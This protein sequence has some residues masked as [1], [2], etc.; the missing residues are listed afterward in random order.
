MFI[1]DTMTWQSLGPDQ[2]QG[3][4]VSQGDQ[5][6]APPSSGGP[7]ARAGRCAASIGSRLYIWSGRDGYRK[8]W[9]YQV[10]CQDLWYLETGEE[11]DKD[12]INI[13]TCLIPVAQYVLQSHTIFKAY[14]YILI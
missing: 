8:S 7:R 11:R 2:Q 5:E 4:T 9:N 6:E 14:F 3:Q 10:C 13:S 1:S 12:T